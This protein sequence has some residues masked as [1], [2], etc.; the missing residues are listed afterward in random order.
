[1]FLKE[2]DDGASNSDEADDET[3]DNISTKITPTSSRRPN[4]PSIVNAN[5]RVSPGSSPQKK[6]THQPPRS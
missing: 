4:S 3:I 2:N 5:Q 6:P 1:L